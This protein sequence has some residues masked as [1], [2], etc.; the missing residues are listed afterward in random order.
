M[1]V[2]IVFFVAACAAVHM[3]SAQGHPVLFA[4]DADFQT[5]KARCASEE[6]L[7]LA[8]GRLLFDAEKIIALPL[9][10][11]EMEGRRL[12]AVSREVLSRTTT[13]SLAYRLTGDK[14]FA[15]RCITE[16]KAAASFKDWNPSHFLDVAEMTMALAIGYD[17]LYAQISP[18]DRKIIEEAIISK[19]LLAGQKGGWWVNAHNNW[20]QVCHAGM[21]SGALATQSLNPK[22]AEFTIKRAIENLPIS[23]AALSPKGS[24]PEGPGYWVYGI[25]F[26]VI[27][28]A[29]LEHATKSDHGLINRPGFKETA[30]YPDIVTGPSGQTFNYADAGSSARGSTCALWWFAKRFNRPDLIS[31]FEED[32]FR[33]YCLQRSEKDNRRSRNRFFPLAML[34]NIPVTG[35]EPKKTTL[36][37]FSEGSTPITI[38][39]TSWN[40]E[41]AVFVGLKA[42]TATSSHAHM[43]AGSFVYDALEVRWAYDLGMEGYHG[44]ES[45]GMDLWGK[46]QDAQ[47]W[48]IFRL[49]NRSHNCL[50]IDGELQRANGRA[51]VIGFQDNGKASKVTLDL[52][53]VYPKAKKVLRTGEMR[54]D[55]VYTLTD[56]LSGVKPGARVRWQMMTKATPV[57]IRKG[58]ALLSLGKKQLKLVTLQ[59]PNTDWQVSDASKP[60]NEWDS[61]NKDF[62]VVFF[63]QTVPA[64]S[65]LTFIV[66][67][68]PV[69]AQ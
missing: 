32:A 12:L 56:T 66:T 27:A 47:R 15:D 25:E 2:A 44:I 51:A 3:L 22:L 1:R 26:N 65:N 68:E 20:G 38:Q 43:D 34:W 42:G 48:T 6:L 37:W 41:E 40:N 23:M 63:E 24:Y 36:N 13:L 18:A 9:S 45:R 10:Q 30:D 5:L 57:D 62:K 46:G 21:L 17:W 16:M 67:F 49:N 8:H 35:K 58:S 50:S 39:R 4:S 31:Y 28:I 19:G 60:V 61:P 14:R 29:M 53:P 55:G 52:T 7:K 11:R 33:A 69:K 54:A 59:A 64:N